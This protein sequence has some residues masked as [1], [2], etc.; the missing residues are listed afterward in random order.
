M[1]ISAEHSSNYLNSSDA[2]SRM[3][4]VSFV[5]RSSAAAKAPAANRPEPCKVSNLLSW[6][7]CP[8]KQTTTKRH[9]EH[10]SYKLES[11]WA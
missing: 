7:V 6:N 3:R 11:D 4:S 10:T 9:I 1:L 2:V 5:S 8:V